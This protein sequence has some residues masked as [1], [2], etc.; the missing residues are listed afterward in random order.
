MREKGG[1]PT[2]RG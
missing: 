1:H 2:R